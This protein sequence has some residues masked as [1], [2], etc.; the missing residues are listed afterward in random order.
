M[1]YFF[2]GEDDFNIDEEIG[3]MKA[4][5]DPNFLEMSYKYYGAADKLNFTDLISVLKTQPMMFGKMLIVIDFAKY[6]TN[7]Y[8]DKEIE[9]FSQ[10]FQ[11]NT[12][13]TDIV[14]FVKFPRDDDRKKPDAR[15]KLYKLLMK[16]NAREFASIP[17]YK[18]ELKQWVKNRAKLYNLEI[19]QDGVEKVISML[20]NN[21]R[22]IDSELQKLAV[23]VYPDKKATAKDIEEYC[24]NN[25][26]LFALSDALM[27]MDFST[28]LAE[29]KKLL[30][31]NHPLKIL[32]T[33]HTMVHKWIIIK[34]N[35]PKL[36]RF[37]LTKLTGM[38]EYPIQLAQGK[39]KNTPLSDLIKLKQNLTECEYK[40]KNGQAFDIEK[41]VADAFFV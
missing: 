16:Q 1:I 24:T 32:A 26:D 27:K 10:A 4:E 15:K 28:A 35:T 9:Q 18:E 37:E 8:E 23:S 14:L 33:L 40:I 20:G 38:N 3:R 13:N 21:L 36:S 25:E 19:P 30:D 39:I 5:L 31:K 17:T 41:E 34:V 7:T 2:Y 29:Y 22:Q 12:D 11:D 6:L